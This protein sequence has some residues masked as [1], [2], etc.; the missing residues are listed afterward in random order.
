MKKIFLYAYDKINLGDDL[1]IE[2]IVKR[3]P[4]T[5]FYMISDKT[6]KT[7]F[8]E[9]KN[10]HIIDRDCVVFKYLKKIWQGGYSRYESHIKNKCDVLVYIGGSIF[11]EYPSWPNIVNW[12]NYQATNYQL[13]IIGANFG[14]FQSIEYCTA[15]KKVFMNLEDICFRDKY[16]FQLFQDCSNARYAPDI[17]FNQK[18]PKSKKTNTIFFSIINCEYKDEGNNTL[19]LYS[20]DYENTIISLIQQYVIDGYNVTLSSFCKTEGDEEVVNRIAQ[21]CPKNI[22]ILNYNG[23]NRKEL[24]YEIGKSCYIVGTRFHAIILG[25]CANLPVFPIIY[26]NKTKNMLEDIGFDGDYVYIK[27]IT[28]LSYEFSKQNLDQNYI[29]DIHKYREKSNDHFKKLDEV[30]S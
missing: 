13:Y 28:K 25:M 12:W 24:I 26:S 8:R 9:L 19:S 18:I 22:K 6:N 21:Q 16:S 5:V 30:L 4:T 23:K 27:D 20:Q 14:P 15:M 10:L 7:N 3:Y 17:L 1:F 11:I 2:T 29:V